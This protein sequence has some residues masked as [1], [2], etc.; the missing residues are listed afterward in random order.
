MENLDSICVRLRSMKPG[1]ASEWL[2][3]NFPSNDPSYGA[4]FDIIPKISWR[5]NDQEK[6]A[7]YYLKGMPFANGRAYAALSKVM[8]LDRFLTVAE[9]CM[10]QEKGDVELALYYLIPALNGVIKSDSDR[11]RLDSFVAKYAGGMGHG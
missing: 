3:Q 9:E 10:P 1:E 6:L 8:S 7:K 11:V 5:K 2:L 4:V